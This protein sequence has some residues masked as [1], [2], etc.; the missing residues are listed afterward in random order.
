MTPRRRSSFLLILDKWDKPILGSHL[1]IQDE[2]TSSGIQKD[3]KAHAVI[4]RELK[5]SQEKT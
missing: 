1:G 4:E 3:S 2:E 5:M